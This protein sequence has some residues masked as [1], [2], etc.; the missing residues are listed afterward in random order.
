MDSP[1]ETIRAHSP[2]TGALL[3]EIRATAPGEVMALLAAA[4]AAFPAW[5]DLPIGQRLDCVTRLRKLLVERLDE[6]VALVAAATGKPDVEALASDVLVSVDVLRYYEREARQILA[7]EPRRGTL[8]Y[9]LSK[10]L[11]TYQPMGAVAVIAPWNHPLQLALV[12]A[13]A[14]LIAGNTVLLK[15]SELTPTVGQL[16]AE[17]GADAGLP[18]G[19]LT[20]LQGGP[21]VGKA[22]VAAGP[23]KIFFTGSLATGRAILA[24][25]AEGLIPVSLELGGNDPMIVFEDADLGRAV[26]GATYGAFANAGQNCVAVERLYV[27]RS[28]HDRFLARVTEAAERLRVG[29]GREADLGPI[30]SDGQREKLTGLL[31][32]ALGR[33]AR[34]TTPIRWEGNRLHPVVLAGVD[35]SMRIMQTEVFGPILPVMPFDSEDEAVALANDSPHGLNS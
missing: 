24:A 3:V 33:G 21:E 31:E 6:V 26:A 20:V 25:A 22:L 35:H 4:R 28:I 5:R 13:V 30:I 1:K 14:A 15:P 27:Q 18:R 34:P 16:I 7:D 29:S 32:D 8:L 17:L 2:A 11:V 10:F 9:R 23:D 12:P 19:A